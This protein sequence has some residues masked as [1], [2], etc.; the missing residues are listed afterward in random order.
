MAAAVAKLCDVHELILIAAQDRAPTQARTTLGAPRHAVLA[1]AAE[2]SDRRPARHHAARLLGPVARRRRLPIGLNPAIDTVEN[3]SRHPAPPRRAAPRSTGAPT[4]ICVLA[5]IKT[6]LACLERG[7]PVEI[8][9]Q[10]LA[11]TESTNLQRVRHHRRPARPRL[12][13]DG[14]A[15]RRS[16]DVRR[17]VHVL[18]DRPGE[19]VHL[20]QA[21]RHRHDDDRGPVLR[22]GPALRPVHGQQRHRLHRPGDAP[23]QLRDDPRQPAGPLHGQAAR[24]CRWAWPPATRCTPNITLEGPADGH[25]AADRGRG[26]LLHGRRA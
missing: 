13:H 1:A 19:R 12:P 22:P 8:L 16:Q 20:R 18:R 9:F 26:E 23:R 21:Q 4:Q 15:R 14:R 10:S 3:V 11:G 2:P 7:A 24:A 17:A 25:A 6:Q 5:H